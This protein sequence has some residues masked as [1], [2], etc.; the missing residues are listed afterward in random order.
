MK[1]EH[2]QGPWVFR[3]ELGTVN[4]VDPIHSQDGRARIEVCDPSLGQTWNGGMLPIDERTA[5]ARLIAAAPDLLQAL[6]SLLDD[7][8]V[9]EVAGD[10]AIGQ[11]LAAIA[12]ARGE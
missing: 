11:A 2:T 1:K 4:A 8:D 5:N 3:E 10:D 9:C 12:R 6:E 7:A